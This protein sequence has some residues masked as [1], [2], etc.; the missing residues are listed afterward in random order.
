MDGW[1][2]GWGGLD[3]SFIPTR[4]PAQR[5]TSTDQIFVVERT[6][7]LREERPEKP[8]RE[9][10]GVMGDEW[11]VMSEA[12]KQKYLTAADAERSQYQE[13]LDAYKGA[14]FWGRGFCMYV[15]V[16]RMCGLAGDLVQSSLA[17]E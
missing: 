2:D 1:V 3:V 12:K 11:K 17:D 7:T 8:M 10:M 5:P 16:V 14:C 6:K 4:P 15:C 13:R 9:L